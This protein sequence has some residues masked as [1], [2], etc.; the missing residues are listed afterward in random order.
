V[1]NTLVFVWILRL[2]GR[3]VGKSVLEDAFCIGLLSRLFKARFW[4]FSVF[5]LGV[6]SFIKGVFCLAVWF[7]GAVG[8]LLISALCMLG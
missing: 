5:C 1:T 3:V 4:L 7:S 2:E 6:V 8:F